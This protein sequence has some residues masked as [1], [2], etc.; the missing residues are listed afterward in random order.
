MRA[1]IHV[2][3]SSSLGPIC[4]CIGWLVL[5]N[6]WYTCVCMCV[7]LRVSL[8]V[9]VCAAHIYVCIVSYTRNQRELKRGAYVC[10]CAQ[11]GKQHQPIE[12]ERSKSSARMR[13]TDCKS[14]LDNQILKNST[15]VSN[16]LVRESFWTRCTLRIHILC[17]IYT[18]KRTVDL[19]LLPLFFS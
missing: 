13:Q 8:C 19:M 17:N 9:C 18:R 2:S 16:D 15:K 5:I 1:L 12:R 6:F 11:K 4:T 10:N 7:S 3:E 14:K